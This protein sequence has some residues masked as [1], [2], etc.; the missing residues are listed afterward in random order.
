MTIAQNEGERGFKGLVGLV[1][2]LNLAR[3]TQALETPSHPQGESIAPSAAPQSNATQRLAASPS[4]NRDYGRWPQAALIIGGFIVVVVLAVN[5]NDNKPSGYSPV[6]NS[7]N[8]GLSTAPSRTEHT[9]SSV[10]AIPAVG[11]DRTL[12]GSELTYCVAQDA[13]ITA[14]Q[15][16]VNHNSDKEIKGINGVIADFNSRCGS[17][18]YYENEM[19]Q[20]RAL[21][22]GRRDEIAWQAQMW[23]ANW[24]KGK[25]VTTSGLAS[26]SGRPASARYSQ[27]NLEDSTAETDDSEDADSEDKPKEE[28]P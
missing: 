6:P 24:R 16:Q 11:T 8:T 15:R 27:S 14:V 23:L 1:S 28:D 18:R 9:A 12:T 17:F 22:E 21:V 4:R 5:N 10:E 25:R 3:I 26:S 19:S 2:E 7:T 13:R 20:V